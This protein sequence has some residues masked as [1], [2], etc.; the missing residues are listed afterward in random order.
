MAS[1]YVSYKSED[2]AFVADVLD[3]LKAQHQIFVDF[4]MPAGVDWRSHLQGRLREAEIFLVF[5]SAFTAG[6]DYQNTEIGAAR[7]SSAFVDQK[8]ILPIVIDPV[9]IPRPLADIDAL[10]IANRDPDQTA[11]AIL[12]QIEHRVRQV[13]L[14]ISHAHKDRDLAARLVDALRANLVVPDGALRCTSVPGYQLDLGTMAPDVLRRELGSSACVVALLTPHSVGTEWVLF[15][16]GAAWANA[17][18]AIPLLVGGVTDK[19]I[20]GPFRG[21]AGGNLSVLNTVNLLISQ[22]GQMLGWQQSLDLVALNKR[23]ELA[24]YAAQVT[25]TTD[26]VRAELNASFTAKWARIGDKQRSILQHLTKKTKGGGTI[27]QED[28]EAAFANLSGGV[29]YRLEQLRLLGFLERTMQTGTTAGPSY[30][31]GLAPAYRDE[32]NG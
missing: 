12:Q 4:L 23:Q 26:P 22:L 27:A 8:L 24:E 9:P 13:R 16:L 10:T 25:F 14:F 30:V 18:K 5:V 6:S 15:E 31:W 21:A 11:A 28:A 2:E 17:R 19:D 29:Y 20:P 7:F 1:I 32:I 3:R